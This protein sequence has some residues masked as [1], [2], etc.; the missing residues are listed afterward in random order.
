[1]TVLR[2]LFLS[3]AVALSSSADAQST[4]ILYDPAPLISQ[5]LDDLDA[6]RELLDEIHNVDSEGGWFSRS[7]EDVQEDLDSYLDELITLIIDV[8]YKDARQ[9]LLDGDARI[10]EIGTEI[11]A[12]RVELL[13]APASDEI[14]TRVDAVLMRD[15]APGSREAIRLEISDL[16]DELRQLEHDRENIER[17]FQLRLSRDYGIELTS[18]QIRSILYQ[19]NGQSIVEASVTFSVLQQV[20]ARLGEIRETVGSQETLQRYYGVAAIMRLIAV[21]LHERH[22]LDYREAWLPTLDRFTEDNR[23]LI[24]ETRGLISAATTEGARDRLRVNLGIQ[25][26]ISTVLDDYRRLLLRREG[27]VEERLRAA[28]SDAVL[29]VNTLRTLNQAIVLFDQLS[30]HQ[31]EFEALMSIDNSE[32]IPLQDEDLVDDF[33]DI[34]RQLAGS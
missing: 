2:A 20:E 6:I 31:D 29:A 1:M 24:A 14:R 16:E 17:D 19:I 26:Q 7:Q 13:T 10:A 4:E 9:R 33:L 8:G 11:D 32:L 5:A 21:R 3:A 15:H 25:N 23:N 34:S 22:L 18:E 12:L 28:A 27:F 30:W